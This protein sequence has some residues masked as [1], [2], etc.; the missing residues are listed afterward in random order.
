MTFFTKMKKLSLEERRLIFW[1]I[2]IAIS[3]LLIY[4]WVKDVQKRISI[5]SKNP[6]GISQYLNSTSSSNTERKV[7][8][9]IKEEQRIGKEIQD[10]LSSSSSTSGSA[11]TTIPSSTTSS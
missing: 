2:M 8:E 4:F 9:V 6:Q 10:L 1:I 5:F 11:S 3:S 7:H